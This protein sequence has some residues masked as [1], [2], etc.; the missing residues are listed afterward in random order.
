V[1]SGFARAIFGSAAVTDATR[2]DDDL[3]DGWSVRVL[4][5]LETMKNLTSGGIVVQPDFVEVQG[6]TG[7]PDASAEIARLLS[8]KLGEA[9]HFEIDVVYDEKLDPVLG[10]P[11]ADECV[12]DIN[13]VIAA[14]KITFAPGSSDI[15]DAASETVDRIAGLMKNCI[16]FPMEIGGHTDSQGREEMNQALSQSRAEAVIEAL[17]QRRVLTSNLTARGYGE[18]EPIA[19][20]GTE[21]GREANRRIEFRRVLS[22][23]ETGAAGEDAGTGAGT[24]SGTNEQN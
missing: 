9:A 4:A 18:A 22:E 6:R 15:E 2:M 1:V 8:S 13:A 24:D 19:D 10:L 23:E 21:A 16:E 7:L 11:T 12:T 14:R 3:P 17:L 5:S 20:N